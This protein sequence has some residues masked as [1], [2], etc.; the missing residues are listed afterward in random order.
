[1][2]YLKLQILNNHGITIVPSDAY[3][4]ADTSGNDTYC[5]VEFTYANGGVGFGVIDLTDYTIMI[6]SLD[7]NPPFSKHD[8]IVCAGAF[9]Y[10]II[11]RRTNTATVI[12]SDI[13]V[14]VDELYD[15]SRDNLIT[16]DSFERTR[17]IE[18]LFYAAPSSTILAV[19]DVVISG[20]SDTTLVYSAGNNSGTWST[21]CGINAIAMYLRHMAKYF[22]SGYVPST[23]NTESKLKIALAEIAN[24]NWKTTTS[25][26]M[27]RLATLANDY[28]K[29]HSTGS[30][31]VSNSSYTWTKLKNRIDNG[32]GKPC[33][34]YIGAGA[35]SYWTKAHAVLGVGY[36]SGATASSGSI[37]VNSGWVSLGY[38]YV[39]TSIP[40]NIIC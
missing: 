11:D 7:T 20:G 35:T 30:V 15:S 24:K 16:L 9:N 32:N 25:I 10:A 28:I 18:E 22:G 26:S 38:V 12:E 36:T 13:V 4:L 40:G 5:C 2:E 6:Y 37:K 3:Y 31:N 14:A 23:H 1:M 27:A 29:A 39:A 8:E 17:I 19:G 33:V 21:D 34:L